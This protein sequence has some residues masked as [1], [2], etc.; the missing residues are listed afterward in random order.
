MASQGR[1]IVM[2]VNGRHAVVMTSDG[3][4]ERVRVPAMVQV[5]DFVPLTSGSVTQ[6][7]RMRHWRLR[8]GIAGVAA[9][10][11]LVAGLFHGVFV[12]APEAQAYAFVSLDAEPSVSLDLTKQMT[13]IDV[14]GMNPSGDALA[15]SLHLKGQSLNKAVQHLVAKLATD[16]TLPSNDTIVITAASPTDNTEV[17]NVEAQAVAAVHQALQLNPS[18]ATTVTN[19][20]SMDVPDAVWKKAVKAHVSPGQ[21]ATYLLA[22][23]SGAPVTLQD[24]SSPTLQR[25]FAQ[26]HDFQTAVSG[27]DAGNYSQVAAILQGADASS[28]TTTSNSITAKTV[29]S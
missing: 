19:V 17:S 6:M 18:A 28:S 20:Y 23:E 13:V 1:G 12:S 15:K 24:L 3:R 14:R 29:Q 25:V 10:V 16:D 9:A 7:T 4:F 11:V 5:G 8:S 26:A 21:Y 27:L 2:E 22:K